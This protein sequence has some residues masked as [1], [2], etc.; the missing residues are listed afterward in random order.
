MG[1][2]DKEEYKRRNAER[3]STVKDRY[4]EIPFRWFKWWKHPADRFAGLLFIATVVLVAVTIHHAEIF[5]QQLVVMQGQLNSMERDQRA[6]M[7]FTEP[8]TLPFL[9]HEGGKNTG[10]VTWSFYFT[11]MGKAEATDLVIDNY[12]KVGN[13]PFRRSAGIAARVRAPE[14]DSGRKSFFSIISEQEFDDAQFNIL[15]AQDGGIA[16]LSVFSFTDVFGNRREASF[17]SLLLAT[18]AV[19]VA[20]AD[21]CKKRIQN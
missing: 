20:N 3:D 19:A 8:H 14:Y 7:S 15:K 13:Q 12:M 21:D 16:T 1:Y 9:P 5:S 17:C 2:Q 10:H 18:G 6:R 11:N 4:R